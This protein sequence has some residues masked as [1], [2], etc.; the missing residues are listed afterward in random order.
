LFLASVFQRTS[1]LYFP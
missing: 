1:D